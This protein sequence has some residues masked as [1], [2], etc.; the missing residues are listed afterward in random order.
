MA[1]VP[2]VPRQP[3]G[4]DPAGIKVENDRQEQDRQ[5]LAF[6]PGVEQQAGSQQDM[7]SACCRNNIITGDR[8]RQE[9]EE[10]KIG[11]KLHWQTGDSCC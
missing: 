6:T 8:E 9:Q 11:V 2:L 4:A 1:G 5:V 10:K 7:I 3:S